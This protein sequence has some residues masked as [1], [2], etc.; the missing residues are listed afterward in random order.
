[1]NWK[2]IEIL[3]DKSTPKYSRWGLYDTEIEGCHLLTD[4]FVALLIYAELPQELKEHVITDQRWSKKTSG[5]LQQG[6]HEF[7]PVNLGSLRR[8]LGDS[9][10]GHTKESC[11]DCN[12]T[13]ITKCDSCDGTGFVDC[14]CDCPYCDNKMKCPDCNGAGRNECHHQ[15]GLDYDSLVVFQLPSNKKSR[16]RFS[17]LRVAQALSLVTGT[18]SCAKISFPHEH[19]PMLIEGKCWKLLIMPTRAGSIPWNALVVELEER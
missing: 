5:L 16:Q 9:V 2:Q 19:R 8:E 7:T 4:N 10:W 12:G 11:P 15:S 18:D 13:G 17:K 6:Y 1:M 3:A 14:D